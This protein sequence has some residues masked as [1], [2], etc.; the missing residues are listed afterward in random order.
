MKREKIFNGLILIF[1]T[2]IIKRL[3]VRGRFMQQ[4]KLE[5]KVMEIVIICIALLM[6]TIVPI[7]VKSQ[8]C[9]DLDGSGGPFPDMGDLTVF[10]DHLYLSWGPLPDPSIANIDDIDGVTHQD[11]LKLIDAI[12]APYT[13]DCS[14]IA[15][16]TY[17]L[18]NDTIRV[19]N[20]KVQPFHSSWEVEVWIKAISPYQGFS[21][22]FSFC[23]PTSD[24]TLD[25]IVGSNPNKIDNINKIA[26]VATNSPTP[27]YPAGESLRA[28]LYFSID[29]STSCQDIIISEAVIPNTDHITM[30]N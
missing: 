4:K 27:S 15:D 26:I 2:N 8:D 23:S 11:L 17:P 12:W 13:V 6:I 21:F 28:T 16:S 30:I 22:P 18:S 1:I 3:C 25:S 24:L 10:I 7:Q 20:C 29:K 14:T 9:G 19:L 5:K